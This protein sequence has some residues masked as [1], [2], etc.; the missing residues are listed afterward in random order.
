M[1]KI[2]IVGAEIESP[3]FAGNIGFWSR[4]ENKL[5]HN[6]QAGR[7]CY[8]Q[9]SEIRYLPRDFDGQHVGFSKIALEQSQR[10]HIM[11]LDIADRIVSRFK[12]E[13]GTDLV[14][15]VGV[16]VAQSESSHLKLKSDASGLY[17]IGNSRAVVANRISHNFGWTGPSLS[18]DTACSSGLFAL[19]LASRA[20]E[21]NDCEAALV[22]G[23]SNFHSSEIGDSLRAAQLLSP[24]GTLKA[25]QNDRNGYVRSEGVAGVL[26]VSSD[27]AK[28]H[29]LSSYMTICATSVSHNSNDQ[30]FSIPDIK[31][32]ETLYET[33]LNGAGWDG[34][35]L[36]HIEMHATGTAAGDGSELSGILSVFGSQNRS[37]PLGLGAVKSNIGHLEGASA[38]AAVIKL[39]LAMAKGQMPPTISGN[40][41]LEAPEASGIYVHSDPVSLAP[42]RDFKIGVSSFGFGGAN[43][44]MLA[45]GHPKAQAARKPADG[46]MDSFSFPRLSQAANDVFERDLSEL[47]QLASTSKTHTADSSFLSSL[48]AGAYLSLKR[49]KGVS[50]FGYDGRLSRHETAEMRR[51]PLFCFGGQSNP[52]NK[53]HRIY[54]ENNLLYRDC[55]NRL[56][57]QFEQHMNW[58]LIQTYYK[59]HSTVP[60]LYDQI[61]A[62]AH[63]YA[64]AQVL[65]SFGCQPQ[66]VIG[67]S[68][69]EF[70]ACVV[71]KGMSEG[72]AVKLLSRRTQAMLSATEIRTAGSMAEVVGTAAEI[73][74]LTCDLKG[75]NVGARISY[76]KIIVS[77]SEEQLNTLQDSSDNLTFRFLKVADAFH[78]DQMLPAAATFDALTKD[79]DDTEF[80][81]FEIPVFSTVTGD[82]LKAPSR[83]VLLRQFTET[84][85]FDAAFAAAKDW[86][87][88]VSSV[89]ISSTGQIVSYSPHLNERVLPASQLADP[90]NPTEGA[91]RD[92][93]RTAGLMAFNLPSQL[94]NAPTLTPHDLLF[95][96]ILPLWSPNAKPDTYHL[97]HMVEDDRVEQLLPGNHLT[98]FEQLMQKVLG[99]YEHSRDAQK[100]WFEILSDSFLLTMIIYEMNTAFKTNFDIS[101]VMT[102]YGTPEEFF[103]ILVSQNKAG[104]PISE[105]Q[106]SAPSESVTP[107]TGT[108]ALQGDITPALYIQT[109]QKSR[110]HNASARPTLANP[111]SKS[112]FQ[113][114]Y[115]IVAKSHGPTRLIDVDGNELVDIAMGFGTLFFGHKNDLLKQTMAQFLEDGPSIGPDNE[116]SASAAALLCNQTGY[117]RAAFTTTGTEAVMVALRMARSYTKRTKI[118]V[119]Q[120]SYHGHYDGVLGLAS[121]ERGRAIP[122]AS[123]IS[124]GAVSEL[125]VY[126]YNDLSVLAELERQSD[127]IAAIIVEPVQSR[128]LNLPDPQ[129]LGA[130]R[131]FCDWSESLLIYDE[132]L[133]GFRAGARGA[134]DVFGVKPDLALFGKM[135]G[136]S[137]PIAAI[138]GDA[139]FMAHIDGGSKQLVE[140]G[141][142]M[143]PTTYLQGTFN[144]NGLSIL[145][146]HDVLQQFATSP[147]LMKN[148]QDKVT[149]LF[150]RFQK[151]CPENLVHLVQIRRYGSVFRFSTKRHDQ[152]FQKYMIANGVYIFEAGTCF[153]SSAH[154]AEDIDVIAAAMVRSLQAMVAD[155]LLDSSIDNFSRV[156]IRSG[157][158]PRIQPVGT[159]SEIAM[160]E[161]QIGIL[162]EC[163]VDP[164]GTPSNTIGFTLC[165]GPGSDVEKLM[166]RFH[167]LVAHHQVFHLHLPEAPNNRARWHFRKTL[168]DNGV[169]VHGHVP[170][171]SDYRT[172]HTE[173]WI[174][175]PDCP[176]MK[177][178]GLSTPLKFF[179]APL[180][181]VEVVT[182]LDQSTIL[183]FGFHHI[184]FDGEAVSAIRSILARSDNES[185]NEWLSFSELNRYSIANSGKTNTIE[186]TDILEYSIPKPQGE[187]DAALTQTYQMY[188]SFDFTVTGEAVAEIKK[189]HSMNI[190]M[191]AFSIFSIALGRYFESTKVLINCTESGRN[192]GAYHLNGLG[193]LARY[194]PCCVA[195]PRP[196]MC[197][198]TTSSIV[199]SYWDGFYNEFSNYL[200]KLRQIELDSKSRNYQFAYNYDGYVTQSGSQAGEGVN[201][202]TSIYPKIGIFDIV[203]NV[204]ATSDPADGSSDKPGLLFK[205]DYSR[206]SISKE[207]LYEVFNQ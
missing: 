46:L 119:F 32:Q 33:A 52:N 141:D 22:I 1:S 202:S 72:L 200:S 174:T 199:T 4:L 185:A 77:G 98:T 167:D 144:K 24:T 30:H 114:R 136:N 85:A 178:L 116:Y 105:S 112:H 36:D 157:I 11:G 29:S 55:I 104:E 171:P 107:A 184:A 8:Q 67:Y 76:T 10:E 54:Y 101:S 190:N 121:V 20:I 197:T 42:D 128:N 82:L 69:G 35:N 88:L 2:E 7:A 159:S 83:A 78:S 12:A 135:I 53:I 74:D 155:E 176:K 172:D 126:P 86:N 120:D 31:C 192:H 165:L 27:F 43:A 153:M 195:L 39:V 21:A 110:A 65:V 34:S 150:E 156:E 191:V 15:D 133:T 57:S 79:L 58:N 130:L 37:K 132:I 168:A 166:N 201:A 95:A 40:E 64:V 194:F 146:L 143:T 187:C 48:Q 206:T 106:T 38:L 9:G 91:V 90:N 13:T 117:D 81:N 16:F 151:I 145:A 51:I 196:E 180:F 115:P 149:A 134:Q 175:A 62:F 154:T 19:H 182:C 158:N 188:D 147:D 181:H 113:P 14:G 127:Q 170:K 94:P 164:N 49:G 100:K 28:R 87:A 66:A 207:K 179:G 92:A 142:V 189:Q 122:A 97:S 70:V 63:Q 60:S 45:Q 108:S 26:L 203:V 205:I 125:L 84:V 73:H 139:A 50:N 96:P 161:V 75:C 131:N 124:A 152:V 102:Q 3:L 99:Q 123:G 173:K 68:V 198:E 177:H 137:M 148:A 61:F 23:V 44:F 140:D 103:N 25:L 111:R 183:S 118:V 169:F 129:F 163:L 93:L 109:T 41:M 204:C 162:K 160:N 89:D 6:E 5:P 18:I 56:S 59:A 80:S 47:A 186:T 71:A 17:A 138:A 193:M